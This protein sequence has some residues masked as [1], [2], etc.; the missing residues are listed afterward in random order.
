[1]T[2]M[3]LRTWLHKGVVT[4]PTE[5]PMHGSGIS[6]SL[7]LLVLV[8]SAGCSS[9]IY[10][11]HVRT[12]STAPTPAV[13][14][15]MLTKEPVA[16]LGALSQ[17]LGGNEIAVSTMLAQVLREVAPQTKVIDPRDVVTRINTNGVADDYIRMRPGAL[18]SY[19]LSR[20]PLKKIGAAIGARYVFQPYMGV[21]TQSMTNRWSFADVRIMQTRSSLTRLGVQLWDTETG[22]LL[23]A[24]V[25][26]AEVEDEGVGQE[27]VYFADAVRITLGSML[28][29]FLT[30]KTASVY[31]PLN[32][33]IDQLVQIPQPEAK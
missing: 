20:D 15:E 18:N 6:V 32:K 7:L 29:D 9:S 13:N 16:V 31:S 17:V 30:G 12:N 19:I 5:S 24:S 8:V 23:W 11:W 3:T 26:E 21:F 1:M 22:E 14:K 33:Y 28:A 25:A 27:P 4:Q 2:M 10:G